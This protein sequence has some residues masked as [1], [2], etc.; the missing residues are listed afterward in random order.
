MDVPFVPLVFRW[1]RPS[2]V[3]CLCAVAGTY[4]ANDLQ[5]EVFIKDAQGEQVLAAVAFGSKSCC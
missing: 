1:K 3:L 2:K 4:P 5:R